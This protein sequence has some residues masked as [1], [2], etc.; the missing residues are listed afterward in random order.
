MLIERL[1]RTTLETMPRIAR[2]RARHLE[3][4]T[5][6]CIER[7]NLIT[8]F[9]TQLADPR[10]PAPLVVA[11]RVRHY[12]A[13]RAATFHDDNLL[14]GSTTSKQIGAPVFP[15]LDGLTIWPELELISTRKVNPQLLSTQDAEILNLSVFP[16]WIDKTVLE[17]V[18]VRLGTPPPTCLRLLERVVYYASGTVSGISHCVPTYERVLNEGM[19]DIIAEARGRERVLDGSKG[20]KTREQIAFYQ[21]VQIALRGAIEHAANLAKAARAE[22]L[23]ATE[24]TRQAELEVLAKICDQ[25]PAK[26]ARSFREAVNSLWLCQIAIHAENANMGTS[27]GRLDQILWQYY[28]RDIEDNVLTPEQALELCCCLWLKLAD[29]TKLVPE[30]AERLWGGAGSAPAVTLGGVDQRGRD[31]VNDLT[32]VFLRTT[33]L[34]ALRDPGVNARFH[35]EVNGRRYRQRVVEVIVN[36]GAIPALHND[37]T[38]ISALVNQGQRLAHARDYAIGGCVAL[39]SAGRDDGGSSSIM[40]NLARALELALF[41]GKLA[42][43]D[44]EQI[45]PVTA[46]PRSFTSFAQFWSVFT[47][48]LQWLIEQAVAINEQLGRIHLEQ[49]PT[50]LL[51]ALFEGP[52]DAGKDLISGGATY[53]SSGASHVAFAEV[54]DSLNAIEVGVFRDARVSMNELLEAMRADF[55]P[56]HARLRNYLRHKAPKFGTEDPIALRNSKRLVEFIHTVYQSHTNYRGGRYRPG[57]W[58]MTAHAGHGKL[59]GALPSGRRAHKVFSSGMTPSSGVARG[60]GPAFGAIAA[61]GSKLIP[62]GSAIN[63]KCTPRRVDESK[64]GYLERFGELVEGYF[65]AGGMQ[66]QVDVCSH[67]DLID[68][69]NYPHKYPNLIVQVSGHSAYFNDLSVPMKEELISRTQYHLD[70]GLAAPLPDWWE[71]GGRFADWGPS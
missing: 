62:G 8:T 44:H 51:S 10:E 69:M 64:Q 70:T 46:D 38:N 71:E 48:Q 2:L 4:P 20:P 12:L 31:A 19:E 16:Y 6:V 17:Q 65:R 30:T 36:T 63:I 59:C 37:V 39:A 66:V 32:Y 42:S 21:S 35:H 34:M 7:A 41:Q 23:V 54:C 15:E 33:E 29:N 27:P 68:A 13:Q 22:A 24:P 18:R 9:M 50:P 60:L 26:P 25:V 3:T 67:E 5:E 45:G 47:I 52:L 57:Y 40:L 55:G 53:N 28:R 1:S 11:R 14:A 61:L 43:A 58:T 56:C 49:L